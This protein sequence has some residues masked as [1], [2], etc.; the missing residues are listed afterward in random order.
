MHVILGTP[1]FMPP[2]EFFMCSNFCHFLLA[3]VIA[4]QQLNLQSKGRQID[5]SME[6]SEM[7][8]HLSEF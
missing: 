4:G 8:F 6:G 3:S 1:K 5:S 2:L 7:C